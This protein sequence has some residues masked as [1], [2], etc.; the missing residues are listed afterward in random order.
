MVVADAEGRWDP[1][2]V[3]QLTEHDISVGRISAP[4]P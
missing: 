1:L 2:N 3:Q 4:V